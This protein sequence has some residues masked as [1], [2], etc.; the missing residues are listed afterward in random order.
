[1]AILDEMTNMVDPLMIAGLQ[2]EHL[3][4][5][6]VTS[7]I[8]A[9]FLRK[10]S[11]PAGNGISITELIEQGDGRFYS[12]FD[13][14]ADR[15]VNEGTVQHFEPWR[16][17]QEDIVLAGTQ[18]ESVLGVTT[19][20]IL[21]PQRSL[22]DFPTPQRLTYINLAKMRTKQAAIAG[23]NDMARILWGETIAG[24][25]TNRLPI[26][27][28]QLFDEDG[29]LH[30]L[31]PGDLGT[32]DEGR[33]VWAKKAPNTDNDKNRHIP[34]IFHNSG[35]S[36]TVAKSVLDIPCLK[37]KANVPGYWIAPTDAELFATL[38]REFEGN[39][40]G[41]LLIGDYSL[42][43]GIECIKYHNCYY[44]V[45]ARAPSDRIRHIHVGM[46]DGTDGS[47]F[48]VAW[49]PSESMDLDSLIQETDPSMM[50]RGTPFGTPMKF[51]WY[52]QGWTRSDRHADALYNELQA[53]YA[54][55]CLYRWK[56]FEVRD[57]SAS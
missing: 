54:Y 34:Q 12:G 36:R 44:Y 51:P 4:S 30:G 25:K 49:D 47:F 27:L 24:D 9:G 23:K 1:M 32:W 8:L 31:G 16:N 40:Q 22:K 7:N 19:R 3:M 20:Q 21:E 18:L 6:C 53:K 29:S 57:L 11:G 28:D 15:T 41:P 42:H 10:K 52:T 45:D 37:M 13:V 5:P 48:P 17:L 26:T 33:H 2:A 35:T 39:E 14:A 55:I 43:L 38:S 56:H 46:P 50:P